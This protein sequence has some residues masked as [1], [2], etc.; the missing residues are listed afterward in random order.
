MPNLPGQ[1]PFRI[2]LSDLTSLENKVYASNVGAR[3]HQSTVQ[4]LV[5]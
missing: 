2:A 3:T 4:D 5:R 1:F